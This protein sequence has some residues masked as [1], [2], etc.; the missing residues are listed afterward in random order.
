MITIIIEFICKLK[1]ETYVT[2][3]LNKDLVDIVVEMVY[4]RNFKLFEK[5]KMNQSNYLKLLLRTFLH[6]F[7][8]E[9]TFQDVCWRYIIS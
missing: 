3:T 5:L 1:S 2:V 4:K 6:V 8:L 9:K 7:L